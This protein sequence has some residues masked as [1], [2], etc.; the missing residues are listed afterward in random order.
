MYWSLLVVASSIG[1]GENLRLLP[2]AR[3]K[4]MEL[5]ACDIFLAPSTI[6]GSEGMRTLKKKKKNE[7]SRAVCVLELFKFYILNYL[8]VA[9]MLA[10]V[11]RY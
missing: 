2:S 7:M 5:P 9:A 10:A 8:V 3:T 6:P 1:N 4:S 11:R